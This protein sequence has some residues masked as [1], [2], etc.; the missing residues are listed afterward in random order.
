MKFSFD[1]S[2]RFFTARVREKILQTV[3]SCFPGADGVFALL[4]RLPTVSNLI[5]GLIDKKQ[6]ERMFMKVS[7]DCGVRFFTARV[8]EKIL[9]TVFRN[10]IQIARHVRL[11]GPHRSPSTG[12]LHG[13]RLKVIHEL[14]SKHHEHASLFPFGSQTQQENPDQNSILA[15]NEVQVEYRNLWVVS[16]DIELGGPSGLYHDCIDR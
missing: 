15:P 9:H 3:F 5:C 10:P 4:L 1:C 13:K 6:I 8:R 16:G 12:I 11:A 7:F 14:P 2:V